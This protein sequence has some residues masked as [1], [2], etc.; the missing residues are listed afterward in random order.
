MTRGWGDEP[1]R[2]TDEAHWLRL[3]EATAGKVQA[4]WDIAEQHDRRRRE[5]TEQG[6]SEPAVMYEGARN[7]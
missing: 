7:A 2:P 1:A 6:A 4:A 5:C 3:A